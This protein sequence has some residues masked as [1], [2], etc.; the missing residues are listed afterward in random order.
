[1]FDFDAALSRS[2]F[3]EFDPAGPYVPE[4]AGAVLSAGASL[5]NVHRVDAGVRWRYFGPRT[6]VEDNSRRSNG[7]SLSN[8]ICG[9]RLGKSVRVTLD[10]FNL[11]NAAGSDIGY[12]YT[13]RLPAI[14]RTARF[15][16]QVGF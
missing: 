1:V 7:T 4:A 3:T 11:L 2:R 8:L 6:L 15:S 10:I 9:Y 5:E 14:P 12:V 16:I 13:S